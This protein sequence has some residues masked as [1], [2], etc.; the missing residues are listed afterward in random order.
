ML[1][2]AARRVINPEVG[3]HLCGY[4]ENYP[5]AGVHDDISV[6]ALFLD[7]GTQKALLLSFDLIGLMS[8]TQARFRGAI[9]GTTG[10]ANVCFACTHVHSAPY[11]LEPALPGDQPNPLLRPN[12]LQRLEKW[13]IDAAVEAKSNAEPCVLR[14]NYAYVEENMNR[15]FNFPDRRFL[16]I[17]DNKQLLG[18]SKEYV[19]RELGIIAFRKV[20]TLNQYKAI[21]TNYTSHPLNVGNSSNLVTADYHGALRRRVEENFAGCLCVTTTGAA[22]DNHPLMPESGFASAE[23]MGTRLARQAIMRCYDSVVAPDEKIRFAYPEVALT[24]KGDETIT[25]APEKG[26]WSRPPQFPPHQQYKTHVSLL[27]IGPVLLAGFPGEPMAELGAM[28]KWSSPFL[29]SYAVFTATDCACYFPTYNQFY[30]GGY[31][32]GVT[33]FTRGTGEML[34]GRILE[35]ARGLIERQPLSLPALAGTPG[36]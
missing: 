7:D 15:R 5:N 18:L 23:E 31:E 29:K 24:F 25:M 12:Y 6:T 19:D 2:G 8:T 16:Y 9:T 22:G 34:V 35:A 32:P 28:I 27:G 30:W 13:A 33:Y 14:Y 36:D 10:V 17:P 1:V 21:I 20:G 11:V 26:Q 3:H 4:G